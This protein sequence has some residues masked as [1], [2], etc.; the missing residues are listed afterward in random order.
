MAQRHPNSYRVRAKA[1]EEYFPVRIKVARDALGRDH[2][3]DDMR[4]WLDAQIGTDRYWIVREAPTGR[5][6]TLLF[7]FLAV[8]DAQAFIDRFS[9]GVLIVGEWPYRNPA[10]SA[11][12]LDNGYTIR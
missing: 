1:A 12:E 8:P 7:H 11:N 9:C 5:P 10:I 6:D 4:R 2:H 3:Y